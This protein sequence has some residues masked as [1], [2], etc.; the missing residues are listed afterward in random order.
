MVSA[1]QIEANRRNSQRSTGPKTDAGKAR[2]RG[3]ALKH[4]LRAVTV[5]PVL[6]QEDPQE[7]AERTQEWISDVRPQNTI[8]RDLV[9]QAARLSLGI[10]R[11]ERIETAHLTSRVRMAAQGQAQKLSAQQRRQVR[12]LGRRLLYVAGPEEVKVNKQPLWA[13]DPEMLVGELEESTEGC[14]WLLE[15]WAEYRNLLD[16]KAKWDE[17]V[18]VR[19]IRLQGKNVVEAVYDPALNSI[20]LAWDVLVQEYVEEEWESFR[21]ERPTNDP[22]YNHRLQ[23]REIAPRPRGE[24]EAWAVLCTVVDHQVCRLTERLADNEDREAAEDPDWADRA[25]LDCSP[26]FERHRRHQ[27]AKTRELLRTLDTLRKMRKCGIRH[28]EW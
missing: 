22:A 21:K 8:E 26:E 12:E 20:F 6:P 18:L 17:A 14:R 3:N 9:G 4:G 25:A 5:M 11:G 28:G 7:L 2:A 16:R 24:A 13:D 10:E 15:R 19:F 1:A 23:W 27:S